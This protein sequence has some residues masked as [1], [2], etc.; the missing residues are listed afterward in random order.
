MLV[1]FS[2]DQ[3]LIQSWLDHVNIPFDDIQR[4]FPTQWIKFYTQHKG[5]MNNNEICVINGPWSFTQLRVGCITLNTLATLWSDQISFVDIPKIDLYALAVSQWVLPDIWVIFMGQRK[6]ARLIDFGI[7]YLD[8]PSH[9]FVDVDNINMT[10]DWREYFLDRVES[11][12]VFDLLDRSKM[13]DNFWVID[14]ILCFDFQKKR[15][16]IQIK[17]FWRAKKLEPRYMMDVQIG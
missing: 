4:Q 13:I 10:I 7:E 9:K 5:N 6:K 1:H 3:I 15:V 16:E 12:P 14:D 11:H 8:E 2:S 17:N